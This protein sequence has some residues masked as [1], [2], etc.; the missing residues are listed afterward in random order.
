[1]N[2][3]ALIALLGQLDKRSNVKVREAD[4]SRLEKPGVVKAKVVL[5]RS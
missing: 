3:D 1:M 4:V 2:F 5:K